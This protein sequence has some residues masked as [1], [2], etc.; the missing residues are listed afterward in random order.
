[1]LKIN[2]GPYLKGLWPQDDSSLVANW[3]RAR[4][5]DAALHNPGPG[6]AYEGAMWEH[7]AIVDVETTSGNPEQGRLMEIAV[8]LP[9]ADGQVTRWHSLVRQRDPIPPFIQR[10][11]GIRPAWL[12][13]AP[14]FHELAGTFLELTEGRTLVAHNV[15]FDLT[16]LDHEFARTGLIFQRATLCTERLARTLLPHH[17]HHNLG[18]LCR[19][20][21]VPFTVSHRA[22]CDA[23]ATL[24]LLQRM[25]TVHG[26][27]CAEQAIVPLSMQR[28]A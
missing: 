15:R 10:L 26:M 25:T 13:D 20:Y 8:V 22:M 9:Q 1:M 5:R 16:V 7:L 23:L 12:A 24:G 27:A 17:Q 21:G 11:T 19:H 6:P 4:R 18:A 3:D 28:R 14:P 2:Y